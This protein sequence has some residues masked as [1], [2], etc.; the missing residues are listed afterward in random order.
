MALSDLLGFVY[1]SLGVLKCRPM[2]QTALL[3]FLLHFGMLQMSITKKRVMQIFE[4][5]KRLAVA[6]DI[7]GLN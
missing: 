6:F 1:D 7:H 3:A 2:M 5:R 4:N